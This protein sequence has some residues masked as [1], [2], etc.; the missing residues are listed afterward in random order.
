MKHEHKWEQVW[1]NG[2]R[3]IFRC[4]LKRCQEIG[5]GVPA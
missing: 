4:R 1:S 2:F 3:R 5:Y